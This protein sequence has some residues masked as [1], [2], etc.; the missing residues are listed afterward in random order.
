MCKLGIDEPVP[1]PTLPQD[2]QG[3]GRLCP[4]R[5]D[6]GA[7]AEGRGAFPPHRRRHVSMTQKGV[8]GS[9]K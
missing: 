9:S 8:Q 1:W 5:G 6:C 7:A 4:V 2:G 3:E